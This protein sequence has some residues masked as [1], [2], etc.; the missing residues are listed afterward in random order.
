MRIRIENFTLL[1][2]RNK[3]IFDAVFEDRHNVC[4]GLRI[5][6]LRLSSNGMVSPRGVMLGNKYHPFMGL[7]EGLSSMIYDELQRFLARERPE[8]LPL[9]GKDMMT[10]RLAGL[11]YKK[12][13]KTESPFV[14]TNV[15]G[16]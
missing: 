2:N 16:R 11:P 3:A 10:A 7:P 1:R 15:E 14:K 4:D 9:V 6:A 5:G 12:K 8:F 13:F